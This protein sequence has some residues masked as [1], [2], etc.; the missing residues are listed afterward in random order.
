MQ[1][2][3]YVINVNRQVE[4]LPESLSLYIYFMLVVN[5]LSRATTTG[6]HVIYMVR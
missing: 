3:E 2:D 1:V 4:G 5:E 6:S